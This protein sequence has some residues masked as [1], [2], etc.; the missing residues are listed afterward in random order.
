LENFSWKREIVTLPVAPSLKE[1]LL[2]SGFR[3][4]GDVVE[5][6][7]DELSSELNVSLQ[8]SLQILNEI[9]LINNPKHEAN[10]RSAV[11]CLKQEESLKGITCFCRE[12]DEMLGGGVP[13]RAITE[14]I[15]TPG[16]G[17]TQFCMQVAVDTQIPTM[18]GGIG[19]ESVYIDTEGSFTPERA[20]QMADELILHLKRVCSVGR[21]S[22][23][24][25][26][27]PLDLNR[28]DALSRMHIFRVH[29]NIEQIATIRSLTE[30]LSENTN[31]KLVV[32]D[33]IAFHFRHS[34]EDMGLRAR[35]LSQMAQDLNILANRFSV[36]VLL[37]NQMTM[38]RCSAESDFL[39]L[40]PALGETWAHAAANRILLFWEDKQRFAK[41]IK[42]PNRAEVTVPFDIKEAG[43]RS[44]EN[45]LVESANKKIR[46]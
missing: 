41:L 31:V 44:Q 26:R 28:K 19:G 13:R 2:N 16:I 10:G 43:I 12:I 32:V 27:N 38:K 36:A 21:G 4:V 9:S 29:S 11:S 17:K 46:I 25:E 14:I 24:N 18:F 3:T 7:P 45:L 15:G 30:F 40:A 22:R 42:S 6:K 33:S 1:K 34:Y 20:A 5:L 39:S 23:V 8:D 35:M 37:T